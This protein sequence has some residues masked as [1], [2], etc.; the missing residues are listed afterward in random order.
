[1]RI[2]ISSLQSNRHIWLRQR[3]R[4]GRTEGG[5]VA[6]AHG[7][8]EEYVRY[9]YPLKVCV[10]VGT[11]GWDDVYIQRRRG[12]QKRGKRLKFTWRRERVRPS[13]NFYLPANS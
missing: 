6:G 8:R 1:M 13:F 11:G 7:P 3:W 5:P 10:H 2:Y 4:N 12:H 9:L